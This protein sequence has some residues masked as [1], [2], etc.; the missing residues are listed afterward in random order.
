[1]NPKEKAKLKA[2]VGEVLREAEDVAMEHIEYIVNTV[3]SDRE[4]WYAVQRY[5]PALQLPPIDHHPNAAITQLRSSLWPGK[6]QQSVL[7]AGVSDDMNACGIQR[8]DSIDSLR[9]EVGPT[10]YT[11]DDDDDLPAS[12][13]SKSKEPTALPNRNS[14]HEPRKLHSFA[15]P[16]PS[17]DYSEKRVRFTSTLPESDMSDLT[18]YQAFRKTFGSSEG[19]KRKH[20]EA[21][22]KASRREIEES[23][24]KKQNKRSRR[25]KPAESEEDGDADVAPDL[26]ALEYDENAMRLACK[27]ALALFSPHEK[28]AQKPWLQKP[29]RATLPKATDTDARL[30]YLEDRFEAFDRFVL[31]HVL[32]DDK[33]AAVKF[34]SSA[35]N[36]ARVKALEK[37]HRSLDRTL[38][39]ETLKA[40]GWPRAK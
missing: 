12:F 5:C 29:P 38:R 14:P 16:P 26:L 6:I 17:S 3:T 36:T 2:A 24:K 11:D 33:V 9:S 22:A 27:K 35:G 32:A 8:S 13:I 25:D 40:E 21:E 30:R 37:K 15:T 23:S 18:G 28:A 31:G 39:K 7:S 1:M 34:D 19:L 20:A 4:A 10:G